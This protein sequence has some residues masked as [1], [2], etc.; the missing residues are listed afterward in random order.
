ME[1]EVW[2]FW[3][4][5]ASGGSLQSKQLVIVY[6]PP[7]Y[8]TLSYD[9]FT[10][11]LSAFCADFDCA[12]VVGDFNM[13]LHNPKNVIARD[14]L[15]ILDIFYFFSMLQVLRTIKHILDLVISKEK[16]ILLKQWWLMLALPVTTVFSLILPSLPRTTESKQV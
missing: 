5:C 15:S 16:H 13:H 14:F 7:K 1:W 12:V 6:R 9:D 11:F 4:W 8:S 3:M 2:F 10:R